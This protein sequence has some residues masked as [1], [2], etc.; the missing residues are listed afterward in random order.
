[1]A[2]FV[3]RSARGTKK[4]QKNTSL[5][6]LGDNRGTKL[7]FCALLI[8]IAKLFYLVVIQRVSD[9]LCLKLSICII[10]ANTLIIN[11][12]TNHYFPMQHVELFNYENLT[13]K[14]VEN[15]FSSS[16]R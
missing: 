9:D 10:F 16:R 8:L 1:M 7:T 12:L 11:M 5:S 13:L 2:V 3:P 14:T 4:G 6:C 15:L